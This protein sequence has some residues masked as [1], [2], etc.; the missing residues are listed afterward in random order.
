MKEKLKY[1]IGIAALAITLFTG[2]AINCLK[3]QAEFSDSE[4]RQLK[5]HPEWSFGS[6]LD[7]TY[8]D[9]F[10]DAAMDQFPFRDEFRRIKSYTLYDLF[11]EK[12]NN[13]I[14]I[15][16]GYA[17]KLDYPLKEESV[18][19]ALTSFRYIYDTYLLGGSSKIYTCIVP[20][21][22]YYL[23][24]QNGYP[25]MDYEKLYSKMKDG[26]DYSGFIDIRNMLSI[27]DYYKTDTHWRQEDLGQTAKKIGEKMGIGDSLS[28][29]YTVNTSKLPFYGVYYGQSALPLKSETIKYLTNDIIDSCKVYNYETGKTT[30]VYELNKLSGKDPYEMFLSGAAPL[31]TIE[32]PKAIENK[33]LIV[34]RDSF[35]SSLIPLLIEGYSKITVVDIRYVKSSIL[36][37]YID[38]D[39]RDVLFLY[40]TLLLNDSYSLK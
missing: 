26:M 23:A 2:S 38:F 27:K 35:G 15:E 16:D 40:S 14:Y 30:G 10:E 8:G 36:K 37:D 39:N 9:K 31:L 6:F 18:Q 3:P 28:G 20:D 24:K 32:N 34:F 13:G 11:W 19:N 4:R 21:K 17:A 22:G 29:N 25:A 5:K 33:E 7:N 12:D 1:R